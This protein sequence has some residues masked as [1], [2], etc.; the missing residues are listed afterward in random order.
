MEEHEK[1]LEDLL[2]KVEREHSLNGKVCAQWL[3]NIREMRLNL[4][5]VNSI[6]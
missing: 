4:R 2:V 3:A 1:V 6:D 5:I